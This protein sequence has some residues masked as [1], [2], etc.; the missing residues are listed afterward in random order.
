[1]E[2]FQRTLFLQ[3]YFHNA[4]GRLLLF[5]F[6]SFDFVNSFSSSN[7]SSPRLSNPIECLCTPG[8]TCDE[9]KETCTILNKDAR[10]YQSWRM[11]NG[12]IVTEAGCFRDQYL[13]SQ[14][15]CTTNTTGRIIFCCS[16]HN[17]CNDRDAYSASLR[18]YLNDSF[19]KPD[20]NTVRDNNTRHKP[21]FPIH[22]IIIL[23]II[24][25]IAFAGIFI[26][27]LY[28]I[29]GSAK[30]T[31]DTIPTDQSLTGLLD[32]YSTSITGS[33][34]PL[35]VQRTLA[36]QIELEELIGKG[37][38]GCVYRGKWREDYVAVKIFS[39][40][41]E[42]SWF[43]EVDIYQTTCFRHE[44]ILGYIAADNK[45]AITYTQL[46]L[47]TDY[48]ENGSLYDYLVNNAVD[49]KTM[50][51][52]MFSIASGLCHLHMPIES[53]NGKVALA[54]R[55]LKTKNILVKRDLTC[56]IADLGLAVKQVKC[57]PS[58]KK[59]SS[60]SNKGDAEAVVIDIQANTRVGTKRKKM[61]LLCQFSGYMAPE[62]LSGTM[63]ERNF[64]SFKAA[65]IYALGL[66]YWELLRRCHSPRPFTDK[67]DAD[68]FQL[69]YQD[70]VTPD[71]SIE[72]MR[73]VVCVKKLRP[74]ASP[75][76]Q[77]NS[78]DTMRIISKL[79]EELWYD[80]PTS[81]LNGLNVKK[82]LKEQCEYVQRLMDGIDK[83]PQ[84][85]QQ[86]TSQI[87]IP[88]TT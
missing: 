46:W 6:I 13:F 25:V 28:L 53:T 67:G 68:E 32:E 42:R 30:S 74:T 4:V 17:L 20:N 79:C 38:Y 37:R 23:L 35:L 66:V 77:Q 87:D 8:E 27:L 14:I 47:V 76:W 75:R 70:M 12:V 54:H 56:C 40:S 34:L 63:N 57:T 72:E 16:S 61:L 48:H 83:Q 3:M 65:D 59:D 9:N 80:D 64:D 10:C 50:L 71:P 88:W 2:R 81:R 19:Y 69:P 52:M 29:K 26:A 15:Y 41:D 31:T 5:L 73:E 86:Q 44:H 58:T 22:Y 39:T 24:I 49:L 62:V 51:K 55:D 78:D 82:Q 85:L 18:K 84:E 60:L 1:M 33:A 7:S 11:D 43:R 45:D 21:T 36:R